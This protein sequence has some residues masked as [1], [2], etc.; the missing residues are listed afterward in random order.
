[1]WKVE[2]KKKA[3]KKTR[4]RRGGLAEGALFFFFFLIYA[5]DGER[6]SPH[7]K[8]KA[9]GFRRRRWWRGEG[10]DIF[11]ADTPRPFSLTFW[12]V[13]SP[14]DD[15]STSPHPLRAGYAKPLSPVPMCNRL[16]SARS[17]RGT[18]LLRH[19]AAGSNR[20]GGKTRHLVFPSHPT[21]GKTRSQPRVCVYR[22]DCHELRG[23]YESCAVDYCPRLCFS[24]RDE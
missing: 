22:G 10:S 1:M 2:K 18:L 11:A 16:A 20:R 23:G 13:A 3:G 9:A 5:N 14:G 6:T 12:V 19:E 21:F 7:A 4:I 8:K 15:I 17:H 24:P